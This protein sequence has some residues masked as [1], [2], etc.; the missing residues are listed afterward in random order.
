LIYGSLIDEK[1][2][3]NRELIFQ[4]NNLD[5]SCCGAPYSKNFVDLLNAKS[6]KLD[7][8]IKAFFIDKNFHEID[9]DTLYKNF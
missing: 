9:L 1:K 7:L 5:P 3:F 8:N 2:Q 4:F 6:K